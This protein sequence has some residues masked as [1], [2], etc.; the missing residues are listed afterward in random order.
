MEQLRD[1]PRVLWSP[2]LLRNLRWRSQGD[3]AR[4]A[5]DG[6]ARRRSRGLK[7]EIHDREGLA[8]KWGA[9]MLFAGESM[10]DIKINEH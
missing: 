2:G 8:E 7:Q 3:W 9:Q 5:R 4:K 6:L 1:S 10:K